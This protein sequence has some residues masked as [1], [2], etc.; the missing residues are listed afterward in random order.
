MATRNSMKNVS[1]K[2]TILRGVY[3]ENLKMQ[4]DR[5]E[6]VRNRTFRRR[7]P[8]LRVLFLV[9]LMGVLFGVHQV[10]TQKIDGNEVHSVSAVLEPAVNGAGTEPMLNGEVAESATESKQYFPIPQQFS[11]PMGPMGVLPGA[12]VDFERLLD[13]SLILNNDAV[14][15][16]SVFGLDVQTIVI[17]PGH[18][19]KDPGAVGTFG[20]MEKEIVL[21]IAM[22]LKKNLEKIGHYH[23]LLTRNEDKTMSLAERVAF[24]NA[25]NADLFI[26]LHV[27]ALPQKNFNVTETYYY[28]PPSDPETLKLVQQENRGSGIS[29]R[30]FENMIRKISNTFKE[31]E[32]ANLAMAIQYSLF[33]N[34]KKYDKD[35]TDAGVKI[36]PFI[37]LLGVN[38]PSV[39]VEISCI[40]KKEEELKLNMLAYREEITTF[41]TQGMVRYLDTRN[42]HVFEG[43]KNGQKTRR[44]SS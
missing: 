42:P 10:H 39:L 31:Q 40:T 26:S 20:T 28:G 25:A 16:S 3:D 9:L 14:R 2:D 13:Y 21:D 32:S 38:A 12:R 15:L 1:L 41:L 8:A 18:G 17:D 22:G 19:G 33:T 7:K 5:H 43:E 27:N 23:V 29:T 4:N 11:Y 36:A 34:V 30:N 24:A 35:I 37:V 44:K 6:P